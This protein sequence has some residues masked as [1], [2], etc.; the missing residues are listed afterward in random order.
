MSKLT[1]LYTL[2]MHSRLYAIKP[3]L[4]C[5]KKRNAKTLLQSIAIITYTSQ[6]GSQP[7]LQNLVF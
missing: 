6:I 4:S 3:Q 1:K 7:A 5:K 2:N